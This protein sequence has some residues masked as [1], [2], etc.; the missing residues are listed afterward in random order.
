M[1]FQSDGVFEGWTAE[2]GRAAARISRLNLR[3]EETSSQGS[4]FTYIVIEKC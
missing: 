3:M 2:K 4:F 1:E